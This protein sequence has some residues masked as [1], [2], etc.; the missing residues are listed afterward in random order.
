MPAMLCDPDSWHGPPAYLPLA[1]KLHGFAGDTIWSRRRFE[2]KPDM[3][4]NLS[5]PFHRSSRCWLAFYVVRQRLKHIL[6]TR[7]PLGT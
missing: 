1:M 2:A 5:R 3:Y 4:V 7:V 6:Q